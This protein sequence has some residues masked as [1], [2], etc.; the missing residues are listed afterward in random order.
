MRASYVN[1]RELNTI[2]A[3]CSPF[4]CLC[5]SQRTRIKVLLSM[6]MGC[7]QLTPLT[8][9]W[10]IVW[11]CHSH[12]LQP[13]KFVFYMISIWYLQNSIISLSDRSLP[14]VEM[15]L[16][17][18]KRFQTKKRHLTIF[19][20]GK[21]SCGGGSSGSNQN[22]TVELIQR[23]TI[24]FLLLCTTA[25]F[26]AKLHAKRGKEA[27]KTWEVPVFELNKASPFGLCALVHV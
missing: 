4:D 3:R 6:S 21:C 23:Q 5:R 18:K 2:C 25:E 15:K 26:C 17:R 19:N 1:R 16:E 8:F 14:S 20:E 22:V 12:D 11:V 24:F 10:C 7:S 9:Q 27:R 13:I